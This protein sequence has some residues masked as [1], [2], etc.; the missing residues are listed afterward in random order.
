[1][2]TE[3][4]Y[5]QWFGKAVGFTS[6]FI[7]APYNH[8]ALSAAIIVG[9]AVGH[10]FDIWAARQ[11]PAPVKAPSK[12]RG[13]R[14]STTLDLNQQYL[15]AALGHLA[16]QGGAVLPRHVK[17]A[18]SFMRALS[19]STA[20][21]K[22]AITT[23]NSGKSAQFDFRKLAAKLPTS[24]NSNTAQF[25]VHAMCAITAI[26]PNDHALA[27]TVRLAGF[28]NVSPGFVAKEFGAALQTRPNASEH[29]T[30]SRQKTRKQERRSSQPSANK[31]EKSALAAAFTT[32]GIPAGSSASGAKKAYRKLISKTH[33]DKLPPNASE[34]KVLAATRQM[35][36]LREALELIEAQQN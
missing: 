4:L 29:N 7:F 30:Y 9:I 8:V 34:S 10:M 33:P 16:K 17:K 31:P 14:S 2:R 24:G 23:F 22:A 27:A 1:M 6:A 11:T 35:V 13:N 20:Q 32:L 28:L 36:I 26:S 15:F 5:N 19:L 25:M 18:E 3:L 12:A 21:R